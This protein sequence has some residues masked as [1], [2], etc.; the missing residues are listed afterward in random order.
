LVRVT[1]IE[2]GPAEWTGLTAQLGRRGVERPI[3]V[4]RDSAG[5]RTVL[6]AADGLWRWAF[7]PGNG[8]EG[9]RQLIAATTNWLLGAADTSVGLARPIRPVVPLGHPIQFQWAGTGAP[10]P[11]IAEFVGDTLRR[12]DTLQFDGSGR[13]DFTL[14][15]GRFA[16]TIRG[17]G[18]GVVAVE[19]WSEEFV[20]RTP[21][22]TPHEATRSAGVSRSALRDKGWPYLLILLLLCA[23]WWMRRRMGLR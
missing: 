20:P 23:E 17:G 19:S 12:S 16:Y 6:M 10:T 2:P 3:I 5:I 11:I 1:P 18:R 13:V 22:L 8:E 14:P 4:G 9:Y 21:R 7:R 15:P